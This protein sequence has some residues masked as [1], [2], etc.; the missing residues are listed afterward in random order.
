MLTQVPQLQSRRAGTKLESVGPQARRV[1]SRVWPPEEAARRQQWPVGTTA[2]GLCPAVPSRGTHLPWR[3]GTGRGP[4]PGR[5]LHQGRPG[6][7]SPGSLSDKGAGSGVGPGAEVPAPSPPLSGCGV[8]T[9]GR[10]EGGSTRGAG[11]A[12]VQGVVQLAHRILQDA[13]SLRGGSPEH[14]ELLVQQPLLQPLLLRLLVGEG[15]RAVAET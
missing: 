9:E 12:Q 2:C 3:P 11:A 8:G 1:G 14:R 7:C 10:Q 5:L 6:P 13:F 4:S 15:D